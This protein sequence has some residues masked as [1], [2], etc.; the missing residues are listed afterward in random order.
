MAANISNSDGTGS[1]L[2]ASS[3]NAQPNFSASCITSYY[4]GNAFGEIKIVYGNNNSINDYIGI[5]NSTYDP[6]G[7]G[8]L[9]YIGV[10]R[11]FEGGNAQVRCFTDPSTN[12]SA[13]VSGHVLEGMPYII[14]NLPIVSATTELATENG[15]GTP[16]RAIPGAL[17]TS[18]SGGDARS[19]ANYWNYGLN[20]FSPGCGQTRQSN[21]YSQNQVVY[22]QQLDFGGTVGTQ[23]AIVTDGYSIGPPNTL[24]RYYYVRGL[25]RVRETVARQP[26]GTGPGTSGYGVGVSNILHNYLLPLDRNQFDSSLFTTTCGQGSAVPIYP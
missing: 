8:A 2:C 18:P 25:G 20:T 3:S 16:N 26:S 10:I 11:N 6:F 19:P 23:D 12:C 15:D 13:P 4:N 22:V 14:R 5:T 1:M 24:E 21:F 17:I 9:Q 7:E